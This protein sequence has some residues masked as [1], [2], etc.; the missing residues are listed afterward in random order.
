MKQLFAEAQQV[1]GSYPFSSARL[2]ILSAEGSRKALWHVATSEGEYV[3]KRSHYPLAKILFSIH[4]Q[5]YAIK[6]GARVPPIIMT[7]DDLPY[8]L[9]EDKVYMLYQWFPEARNPIFTQKEDLKQTL[10]ALALF[11]RA[12]EGYVPPVDCLESWRVRKGTHS[13]EKSIQRM[14]EI[15]ALSK[16]E[17]VSARNPIFAY[18]PKAIVRAIKVVERLK[19]AGLDDVI[20]EVH[21]RRLL[22]HEDFG[23]PNALM[24]GQKGY[25]ID[26]DGLS[27]NLPSRDLGKI[28]TRGIR[29]RGLTVNEVEQIVDWY[30]LEYPLSKTDREIL[31]L[32]TLFPMQILRVLHKDLKEGPITT[33]NYAKVV[34]F[35]ERKR[36]LLYQL[37]H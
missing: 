37:L 31:Y 8:T 7:K 19:K 36:A 1:L 28:I 12:L 34:E 30:S 15:N 18:L 22:T 14:I 4:G 2:R 20:Q 10:N 16:Q 25:V 5:L 3:L 33:K 23:E 26:I 17:T 9:H 11:H 32:E 13:Y 27:Y 21:S 29:R 24:I 6:N 35:E